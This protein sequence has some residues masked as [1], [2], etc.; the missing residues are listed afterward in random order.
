MMKKNDL[1]K[2]FFDREGENSPLD[3]SMSSNLDNFSPLS[4]TWKQLLEQKKIQGK[5][6][7]KHSENDQSVQ[8]SIN[9]IRKLIKDELSHRAI[10]NLVSDCF[11]IPLGSSQFLKYISW[12]EEIKDYFLQKEGIYVYIKGYHLQHL[13]IGLPKA[14][15][16]ITVTP[17][18]NEKNS[19]TCSSVSSPDK[20]L[21]EPK[22][23]LSEQW[24]FR[25]KELKENKIKS[26]MMKIEEDKNL[27]DTIEELRSLIEKEIN[28]SDI[29]Y[30]DR[31]EFSIFPKR[32]QYNWLNLFNNFNELALYL[33]H[34]DGLSISYDQP[35]YIHNGKITVKRIKNN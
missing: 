26:L 15:D 29:R 5:V 24:D 28:S 17:S 7:K 14:E 3:N 23:K 2:K 27:K 8:S 21:S 13:L 35:C 4:S 31:Y 1:N 30:L 25:L 19:E 33:E 10:D 12:A 22:K 32:D 34:Q 18:G 16:K 9:E 11:Q 20:L 6:S